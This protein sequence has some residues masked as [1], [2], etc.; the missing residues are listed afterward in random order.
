MKKKLVFGLIF[1][2]LAFGFLEAQYHFFLR[3]NRYW[4]N[5]G[6]FSTDHRIVSVGANNTLRAAYSPGSYFEIVCASDGTS[7]F[8]GTGQINFTERAVANR[9]EGTYLFA[10]GLAIGDAG[11]P[12]DAQGI[13]MEFDWG[14]TPTLTGS[15]KNVHGLDIK[16]TMD[17]EWDFTSAD[18]NATVRGARLQ[19]WSEDDIGGRIMGAYINA[20][21]E[22]TSTVEGIIG[23]T[24]DGPGVVAIEARTELGTS[25]VITTPD[26]VGVLI[27]HN[28]KSGSNLIGDYKAI[29]IC[30]PLMPTQTGTMYGIWFGDDNNTNFYP[31]DYAFG[32]S[33]ELDADTT[34][35]YND[36]ISSNGVDTQ[37]D[38][39]GWIIVEID[40][41]ALYIYCFGTKP[42]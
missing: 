9:G 29:N 33:S 1:L 38:V 20:R 39:D 30:Q 3:A 25:A 8:T 32:F 23:G 31:Y 4:S 35:H 18:R 2:L 13:K 42:S 15:G 19:G 26:V 17:Q 22:G 5:T 37:S 36:S 6:I 28:G 41:H 16:M 27:F 24:D 14:T 21:A 10:N 12:G 7:D 11:E 40:G 34:A